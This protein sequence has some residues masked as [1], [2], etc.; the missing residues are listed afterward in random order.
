MNAPGSWH[1]SWVAKPIYEKLRDRTP[2]GFYLVADTAF[3]HGTDT[4]EGRIKAPLK[5][6]D[7][8]QGT[9]ASIE[10]RLAFDRQL[11]S[12]QQTAEWGNH[13]LKQSF[14]RLCIPLPVQCARRRADILEICIRGHCLHTRKVGRNQIQT[15]YQPIW[16]EAGIFP[17]DF[18][19]TLF[20]EL[21]ANDRV[22]NYHTVAVYE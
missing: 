7:K 17:L 4:V 15:V 3:P 22:S 14:S 16:S 9:Q 12:Y 10:H 13:A 21:R 20:S 6:G 8:L 19:N 2:P 18:H 11:L 5:T 1:D